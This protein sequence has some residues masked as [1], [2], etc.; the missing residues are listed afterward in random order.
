MKMKLFASL[1]VVALVAVLIPTA[2]LAQ[3]YS[4]SFTTSI[5]YQNVGSGDATIVVKFYASPTDTTPIEITRPLLAP[6]AS[7]SLFVGGL[8][9]V[10]SGFRGSAVMES[11]QPILATMVQLP[12]GTNPGTRNRPLSNGFSSTGESQVLIATVLKNQFDTTT[13]FSIQNTGTTA[14][15]LTFRFY[16]TSAVEVHNFA[17][18]VQPGA[19]YYVDA[20]TIAALG[21]SFNGS[22]VV[23]S[24][25]GTIVGGA[26]ELSTT[27]SGAS[28]FEGV[29]AGATT[30]YMPSALCNAFGANTAYAVQNTSLT[31]ST[32]VRVTYSNGV[33]EQ[34]TVAPGAKRSFVACNA[35][36]MAAG[37]SGSA[38]V[39]S[40]A[41]PIIAIGKAYGS[42]LSTAFVGVSDGANEIGLPYVRWATD[43]NWANGTQQRV[44]LTIQNI[45]NTNL[46]AGAVTVRY[47]NRNGVQQG[48]TH[49]LP[50]IAAG[51]KQNS[52][53]SNAGLTE[54]GIDGGNYGGGAIVSAPDGAQLAVVARVSTQI[55]P[56]QFASEDYNGMTLPS[57]P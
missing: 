15:N 26:M 6:N 56:G 29:G 44:Y 43:A 50:A 19:A 14:S 12:Q 54:F 21:A 46:A 18:N 57:S 53:A 9:N 13:L 34:Q 24:A 28:A 55:A 40:T 33:V 1:M 5:T 22:A 31:S 20:G 23:T 7:T 4:T 30:V 41:T 47:I 10:A 32:T 51:A 2:V 52:N 27:G 11:D 37:F 39:E 35:P 42:G 16:N 48:S 3:A 49:S 36:G 38:V 17:Q 8:A 45:G 25:G